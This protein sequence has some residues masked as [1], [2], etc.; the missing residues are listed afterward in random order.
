MRRTEFLPGG[1]VL[2]RAAVVRELPENC[3]GCGCGT[4]TVR[5]PFEAV[6]RGLAESQPIEKTLGE[7]PRFLYY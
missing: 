4:G 3:C 6:N 1:S 5:E 7:H 2:Q